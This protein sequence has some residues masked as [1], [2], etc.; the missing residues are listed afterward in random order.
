[1][2][3]AKVPPDVAGFLAPQTVSL[4]PIPTGVKAEM[5]CFGLHTLGDLAA[6]K[7]AALTD[8]FGP[9]SQRVWEMAQGIDDTTLVPQKHEETIVE[10]AVLPFASASLTLREF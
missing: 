7:V 1:L 2:G 6:M 8:L 5:C 3:A 9:A 4:L 10:H